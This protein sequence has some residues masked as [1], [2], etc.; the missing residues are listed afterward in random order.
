MSGY[1]SIG[2]PNKYKTCIIP[3]P[4]VINW[5]YGNSAAKEKYLQSPCKDSYLVILNDGD[6]HLS[7]TCRCS[8][9]IGI[10][11][12]C[13]DKRRFEGMVSTMMSSNGQKLK[14]FAFKN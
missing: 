11:K 8:Y 3:V 7:C 5:C 10:K 14:Q 2:R 4:K 6:K 1:R 9:T 13:E 12:F